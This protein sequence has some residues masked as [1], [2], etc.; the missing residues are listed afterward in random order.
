[1]HVDCVDSWSDI[2][3]RWTKRAKG[4]ELRQSHGNW[5]A[6]EIFWKEGANVKEGK[7]RIDEQEV[8]QLEAQ[9]YT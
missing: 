7:E 1:M 5:G 2:A 8:S 3:W 6:W 9:F 4:G